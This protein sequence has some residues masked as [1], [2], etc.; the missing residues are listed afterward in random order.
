VSQPTFSRRAVLR[1]G[2]LGAAAL[3]AGSAAW[4]LEAEADVTQLTPLPQGRYTLDGEWLFGGVYAAGSEQPGYSEAGFQTVCVPHTVTPLSWGYW[5]P[6]AWEQLWIYRKHISQAAVSGGRVFV[7][8][9]GVMTSAT[10]YLNGTAIAGHQ[11]GYLPFSV[12]LTESLVAGDNV[13]A[14]VVDG[15]LQDVPPNDVAGGDAAIDYL[16]PAGIY[17]DVALRIVPEVQIADVFAKPV[18]VLTSPGLEVAVTVDAAATSTD[19]VVAV[20][21]INSAGAPIAG[22][23]QRISVQRGRSTQIGLTMSN[24]Q[25]ISLWS[26]ES[27]TLYT[28]RTTVT[29]GEAVDSFTLTT[30]FREAVFELD[31]F[32]LNGAR[33]E[34][35]GLNRHQLFPY[36]GMAGSAR[37]QARDAA[38][39]KNDL[40]CN[41]VRCS[42]YPQSE[43]FLDA[44]D[45]IG[46]MVWE[47]PPG[48]Q[49]VG[50][51]AFREVVLQNVEDMILRDRSRPSVIVWA[52]RLNETN[53]GPTNQS[54]YAD[55]DQIATQLDGSRQTTGAMDIYS[56]TNGWNQQ[57][58]AFDDYHWVDDVPDQATLWPPLPGVPYM[59][60]E[61]V[62]A[63]DGAPTYRWIDSQ[64]TLA[65]QGEMHA[66]V[67]NI[68]QSNPAYAGLLGWCAV[69]YQSLNGGTRIWNNVKTP[70]VTDT[71]R[72]QKP[73]A[74]FYASQQGTGAPVIVPGFFWDFGPDSPAQGPGSTIVFTNCDELRF[75]VGNATT[76]VVIGTPNT[77]DYGNL[78]APP[79]FV[80]F[81]AV[82]GSSSPEL[83]IQGL[84]GGQVVT[85]LKMS[86]D[87]SQDQL[88]LTLDDS[89]ISGDGTD[90]TR[91]TVRGVDEFGNHRPL[92]STNAT[93][94]TYAV[95]GPATL[96]ADN[97]FAFG[98]YGGVGGGFLRSQAGAT[99]P[100]TLTATHPTFGTASVGLDVAAGSPAPGSAGS[101]LPRVLT[102]PPVP[103][104]PPRRPRPEAD[105]QGSALTNALRDDLRRMLAVSGLKSRIAQLLRHGYTLTFRAPSAGM[106][107]VGWYRV[108]HVSASEEESHSTAVTHSHPKER[109]KRVL[110]ASASV[111]IRSKGRARIHVH[112]TARGKTL[113]RHV[114]HEERLEA[115]AQFTPKGKDEVKVSVTRWIK[116]HR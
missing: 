62:G 104:G 25:G 80:T 88:S 7:D 110:V 92:A 33:Y 101:S 17:R 114:R 99:G 102:A 50:D 46:L 18:N 4:P 113:L 15:T 77:T 30:G 19:V 61:A 98:L 23:S 59:V 55:T 36:L 71:F 26:P 10:V 112:L 63:I 87:T 70:G 82:N 51:L 21:L 38:I 22:T 86:S 76:P 53:N 107:V 97:P 115:E 2:A 52:T 20:A 109:V 45:A 111:H 27:P 28:V 73:G 32:Y 91:F 1:A 67:H 58:F 84:V 54:L 108:T 37:L 12:E 85:T 66:Q 116:L 43:Y 90:T 35:F 42:H 81:P 8:F 49:Y 3:A 65:L 74:G 34:I 56:T 57:V 105:E 79:V 16:Q 83:R 24:L 69:D 96:L 94:V 29:L 64:A 5:N 39:L 95:S 31:G 14:V 47:E 13:L 48:W 89:S 40:N 78:T 106:L 72:V 75:F 44:C 6:A 93:Q 103:E 60:S 11:G 68:A 9:Q 100:V 41:M